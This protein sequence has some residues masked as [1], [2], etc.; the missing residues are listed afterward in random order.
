MAADEPLHSDGPAAI[1]AAVRALAS[2]AHAVLTRAVADGPGDYQEGVPDLLLRIDD[3]RGL[4]GDRHF[5]SL[6]LWLDNIQRQ[7]IIVQRQAIIVQELGELRRRIE[8]LEG[9]DKAPPVE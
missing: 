7:A 9:R 2:D 8:R 3:L 4:L 1:A 6:R 5:S